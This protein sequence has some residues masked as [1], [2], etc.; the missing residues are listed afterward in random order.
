MD[1]RYGKRMQNRWNT[2][3]LKVLTEM[4]MEEGL[5]GAYSLQF[6]VKRAVMNEAKRRGKKWPTGE[7]N[8]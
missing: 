7:R 5:V 2:E 3:E 4:A 6:M 8:A 1:K